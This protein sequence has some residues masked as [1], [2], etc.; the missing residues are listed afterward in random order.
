MKRVSNI[1]FFLQ[2]K[3]LLVIKTDLKTDGI[4]LSQFLM[5]KKLKKSFVSIF[6]L[7]S[8]I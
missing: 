1:D 4:D 6:Y 2:F 7:S 3:I 8:G 5:V